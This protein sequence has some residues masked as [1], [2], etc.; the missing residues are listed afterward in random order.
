MLFLDENK[1]WQ[2]LTNKRI[3]EILLE[4]TLRDKFVGLNVMKSVLSLGETSSALERSFKVAAKLKRV[5]STD[6][7]MESIFMEE[8]L[9]LVE[10]IPV[11]TREASQNMDVDMEEFLGVDKILQSMQGKLL[12]N[13][14][15][16]TQINKRIKKRYQKVRESGK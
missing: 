4:K 12:N 10:D 8:L 5:S 1:H 11:K 3:G 14:S 13:T 9:S 6:I 15:K 7:E 2:S 16:L